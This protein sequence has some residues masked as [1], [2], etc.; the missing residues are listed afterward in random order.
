MVRI[1]TLPFW[2]LT[3]R[4]GADRVFT[5]ELI[6]FK[7]WDCFRIENEEF[8]T[9]DF[10]SKRDGS[11]VLRVLKEEK[12]FLTVQIGAADHENAVAA[13]NIVKEDCS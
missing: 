6:S 12:E 8:K 13:A 11:I 5:E 7:L 4:H 1:G 10:V 9:I 3:W 2:V